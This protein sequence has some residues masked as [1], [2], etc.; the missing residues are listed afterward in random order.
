MSFLRWFYSKHSIKRKILDIKVDI[1]RIVRKNTNEGFWIYWY[2]AYWIDP[3][4]LAYI[5][6]VNSDRMKNKL[7]SDIE[8]NKALR[9][10]LIKNDYPTEAIPDVYIG[11]ESDETIQRESDGNFHYHFK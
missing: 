7:S 4:H 10:F 1:K 6:I 3:K 11:F 2:G 5:I 9:S 8:L